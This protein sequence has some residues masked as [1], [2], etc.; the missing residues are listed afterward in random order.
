MLMYLMLISILS[1][2]IVVYGIYPLYHRMQKRT[3]LIAW[4]VLIFTGHYIFAN[5]YM[6]DLYIGD[7]IKVVGV[8]IVWFGATGLMTADSVK[9]EKKQKSIEIIEA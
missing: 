7:M 3:L 6:I 2:V 5:D 8:L 4:L 1:Y 9:K